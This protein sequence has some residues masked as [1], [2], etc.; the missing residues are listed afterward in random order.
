MKKHLLYWL[1]AISILSVGCQKELSFEGSN[2]PAKGSLQADVTGDCLPKTVNGTYVV[3]TTLVAAIN[4]ITVQINVTKTGTFVVYTD[5]L[6]GFYFRATGT[7]TTLGATNVTLRSNGTPIS[8]G[9]GTTN[10]VVN[11][12]TTFCDIQVTVLPAGSGPAVYNLAGTPGACTGGQVFGTYALGVPLNAGDSVRLSVNVV[13]I[14]TWNITT[15]PAVGGM[16]FAGSGTF[17]ATGNQNIILVGTPASVPTINGA[18]TI[19]VSTGTSNCSFIVTVTSPATGTVDCSSATFTGTF[20]AGV[21]MTASNT[22]TISVTVLTTGPYSITTDTINN[23]W[24]NASGNFPTATTTPV[25]LIGHGTPASS[26]PFIFKVKFGTSTCTFTCNFS[27]AVNSDYFPLT[28]NSWWSYDDIDGIFVLGDS[29]TRLNI[30]PITLA[31]NVYRIFQNQDETTPMDSSYFRK[32]GNDYLERNDVDYY[33][34][35]FTFDVVQKGDILFLKEGLTTSQ[36]WES[37]VFNGTFS[38]VPASLKYTFTCTN[39]NATATINGNN[40]TNVYK[41]AWKPQIN[42]GGTGYMDEFLSFESWYAKGVGLI[43]FKVNDLTGGPS[44]DIN[45]QN[46]KVF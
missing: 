10:F 43:Y 31:G 37:A 4:T 29:L 46:W 15:T 25:I 6:N 2:T 35:I 9:S 8:V 1:A 17:T 26:G 28:A 21:A 33:T 36:T 41:I 13:S 12:D 45:I 11:F 44:S 20:T 14:G 32:T 19:P 22:V 24:F 27:A 39:A 34:A 40:F 3:G 30:N 23:V 38:S 5:T 18:N 7:F 16:V 42:I